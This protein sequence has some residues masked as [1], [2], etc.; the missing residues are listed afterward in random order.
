[1]A[2]GEQ[3][4]TFGVTTDSTIKE[5]AWPPDVNNNISEDES[6]EYSGSWNINKVHEVTQPSIIDD[7]IFTNSLNDY[8]IFSLV[9]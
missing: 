5:V 8:K 9:I 7:H 2:K 6:S 1:M 3:C 4:F